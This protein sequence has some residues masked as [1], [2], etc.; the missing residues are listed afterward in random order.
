M[1][2]I[3]CSTTGRVSRAAKRA[4]A[5]TAAKLLLIA[6]LTCGA[7]EL[8]AQGNPAAPDAAKIAAGETVYNT[9]C[10]TCHGDD[11][12]HTGGQAFDLRRL[13]ADERPRFDH[14]VR[15]GK[16]QMPPWNGVLSDEQI[17]RLW[18]YIRANAYEK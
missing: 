1:P 6:A 8:C 14:S 5:P 15:N 9:Y 13:K 3:S 11:L 7:H 17:D 10:A 12:I 2:A 4:C 18:H 16:N